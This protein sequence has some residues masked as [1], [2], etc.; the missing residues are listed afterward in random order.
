MGQECACDGAW[1]CI[2]LI[3][4]ESALI[5]SALGCCAGLERSDAVPQRRTSSSSPRRNAWL[6][7]AILFGSGIVINWLSDLINASAPVVLA[8]GLVVFLVMIGVE[9]GMDRARMTGVEATQPLDLVTLALLGLILGAVVGGLSVLPVFRAHTY[10]VTWT[11]DTLE[12]YE[13]GAVVVLAV[14]VGVAAWRGAQ[15]LELAAFVPGAVAGMT[16]VIVAVKPEN[17]FT[18]TF[19]TWTAV[20]AGIAMLVH[21]R[22]SLLSLLLRFWRLGSSR[23]VDAL[24]G[25]RKRAAP[26]SRP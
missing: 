9:G 14:L 11:P 4:R 22:R 3:A 17:A 23:D 16:L 26:K 1:L 19:L 5:T 2:C 7:V 10:A 24:P 18:T 25:R 6:T 21:V 12:S 20:V 13:I 8:V 15:L